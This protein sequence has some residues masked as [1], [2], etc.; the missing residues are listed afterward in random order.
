M[1]EKYFQVRCE[2]DADSKYYTKIVPLLIG[3][4]SFA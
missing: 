2:E 4:G 1:P 3:V